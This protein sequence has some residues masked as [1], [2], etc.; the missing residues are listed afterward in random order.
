MI[1][2]PVPTS[3]APSPF[4]I[5]AAELVAVGSTTF[6]TDH[7]LLTTFRSSKGQSR[8]EERTR[9]RRR[10]GGKGKEKERK[11]KLKHVTLTPID[12]VSHK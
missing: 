10:S 11:K 1:I 3:P 8:R 5:I 2:R 7:P 12:Q 6:Q 4:R 9:R